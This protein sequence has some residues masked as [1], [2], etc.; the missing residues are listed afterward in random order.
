MI[1]HYLNIEC[2]TVFETETQTPLIIYADAP[3]PLAV[4]VQSFQP[5]AWWN[6][7]I[8]NRIRIVQ[9]LQL[10]FGYRGKGLESAR[11]LS[12]KNQL[13]IFAIEGFDHE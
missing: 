10:T 6:A 4:S 3:L 12:F 2:D 9:H 5:V 13:G 11:A 7:K 1:I 8:F